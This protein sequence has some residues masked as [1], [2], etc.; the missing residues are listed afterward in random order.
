MD[1]ITELGLPLAEIGTGGDP[2]HAP[3]RHVYEKAGFTPVPLVQL[4]Q[5]TPW[6][7]ETALDDS[8]GTRQH[9]LAARNE[10]ASAHLTTRTPAQ[11]DATPALV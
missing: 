3:A 8:G 7:P 2:G 5:G 10:G 6:R 9:R 4:L 1:R 11:T